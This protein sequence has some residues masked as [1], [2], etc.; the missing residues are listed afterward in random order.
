MEFKKIGILGGMGPESSASFYQKIIKYCQKKYGAVQDTD[1]PPMIMYSLPLSGLDET[2]IVDKTGVLNQLIH[3]VNTLEKA[4][5]DFIVIPCNTVH[6]FIDS[7]RLLFSIPII[8]ILEETV[9]KIKQSNHSS[10]G[11]LGSET[12]LKLQLYQKLLGKNNIACVSPTNKEGI[13]ITKLI[14][15]VMSGKVEDKTKNDVL[16]IIRKME[17]QSTKAVI[18]GCTEMPLAITQE[19]VN[20]KVYDTLQI[21]AESAVDYA[22]K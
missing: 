4:G 5:C 12:M 18:L 8:S 15:Q 21:L 7:L 3:G 9:K 17:L 20:I 19:D 13:L 14:L 16:S 1:F 22:S 2:G 6:H 11:I 10:V